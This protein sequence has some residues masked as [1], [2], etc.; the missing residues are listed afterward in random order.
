MTQPLVGVLDYGSGN[1]HSACR[2]LEVAGARVRLGQ[3]PTDFT[4]ATGLVLPG[5]GAFAACMT[6]LRAI[7]ADQLV[8]DWVAAD[9]KLL[10]ICVG[11]QVLFA[12][13]TE[14]GADSEGIGIFDGT[15]ERLASR[16]LPHMGWNTV[17]LPE[18][19][20]GLAALRGRRFYF[21]HSYGVHATDQQDRPSVPPD[22]AA[23][24]TEHDGDRFL[25]AVQWRGV[26]STQFHPEKS[27]AAGAALLHDW[28]MS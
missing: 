11:H 8:R 10:G 5:V 3:F 14:H 24:W 13:G 25:A 16:R 20:S 6:Q 7:G 4:T 27:G 26:T 28:L 1:L 23:A 17:E 22:A 19:A 12:R 18:P 9:R 15:V 21:V 2:A